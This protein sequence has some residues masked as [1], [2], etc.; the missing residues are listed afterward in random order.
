M[1]KQE[2]TLPPVR[3][4]LPAF[5][6]WDAAVSSAKSRGTFVLCRVGKIYARVFPSGNRYPVR[7]KSRFFNEE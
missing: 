6:N 5:L 7:E 4:I 1:R 3:P 2:P